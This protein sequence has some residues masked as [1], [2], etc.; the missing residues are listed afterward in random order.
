VDSLEVPKRVILD[1]SVIIGLLRNKPEEVRLIR[2]L[3]A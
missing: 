1:S 3:E 2:E